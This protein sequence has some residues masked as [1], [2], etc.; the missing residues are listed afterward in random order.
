VVII[1][2]TIRNS[3]SFLS[4]L[5]IIVAH[6]FSSP[7][8][9]YSANY[10]YIRSGSRNILIN[11]S[12]CAPGPRVALFWFLLCIANIA[13]PPSSNLIAEIISIIRIINT[14]APLSLQL[15]SLTFLAGAYTLIL[16]SRTSQGQRKPKFFGYFQ[17]LK[18]ELQVFFL[19]TTILYFFS[20]GVVLA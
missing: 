1:A 2:L 17:P 15:F 19:L 7:G 13:A 4:A 14:R 5:L 3:I 12:R 8:I 11:P 16:F 9:F 18:L 20:L 10:F 6:G